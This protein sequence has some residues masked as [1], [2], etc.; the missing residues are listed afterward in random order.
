MK[1][2][3]YYWYIVSSDNPV[4]VF[5]GQMSIDPREFCGLKIGDKVNRIGDK[6]QSGQAALNRVQYFTTYVTYAGIFREKVYSTG[7]YADMLLFELQE[8]ERVPEV[9]EPCYIAYIIIEKPDGFELRV[10]DLKNNNPIYI[11]RPKFGTLSVGQSNNENI[12]P[13]PE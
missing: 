12:N 7:E 8:S 9:N 1:K 10:P 2:N 3:D 11:L 6:N 13:V 5:I 4:F